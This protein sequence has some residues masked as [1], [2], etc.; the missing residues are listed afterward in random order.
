MQFFSVIGSLATIAGF[1]SATVIP[2]DREMIGRIPNPL[3]YSSRV[4]NTAKR[5]FA[6]FYFC[7][8]ADYQGLCY[9]DQSALGT[10]GMCFVLVGLLSCA[11][12]FQNEHSFIELS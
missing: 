4:G 3:L 10:C 9:R 7:A 6:G 1:V 5:A 2:E 12:M 8:D 11:A